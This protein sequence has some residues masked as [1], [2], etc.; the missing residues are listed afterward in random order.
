MERLSKMKLKDRKI[1]EMKEIQ[2]FSDNKDDQRF[3]QKQRVELNAL[4]FDWI[5]GEEGA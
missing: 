2:A 3:S 5:F 1:Q 4:E